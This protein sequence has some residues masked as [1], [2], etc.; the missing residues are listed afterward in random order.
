MTLT[1]RAAKKLA[2]AKLA[3]AKLAGR[4]ERRANRVRNAP[5]VHPKKKEQQRKVDENDDRRDSKF[6]LLTP[7]R[8]SGQS[9][10]RQT[11]G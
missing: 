1:A 6:R 4:L 11:D 3:A 8:A 7:Q 10:R 9:P 2:V 5:T